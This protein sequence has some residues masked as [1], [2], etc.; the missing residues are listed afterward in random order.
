[1]LVAGM[2]S[3]GRMPNG[4]VSGYGVFDLASGR[5]IDRG[6]RV[7]ISHL[8][9]VFGAVEINSELLQLLDVPRYRSAWLDYCRW[10]GAPK[11]AFAAHFGKSDGGRGLLQGHSR[12]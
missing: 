1:R 9:S 2:D 12:L 11:Q 4:W 6:P 3:I 8:N 5:F 10:Y 7:E